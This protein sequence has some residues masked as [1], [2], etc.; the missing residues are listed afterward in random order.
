MQTFVGSFLVVMVMQFCCTAL[1]VPVSKSNAIKPVVSRIGGQKWG[2][3]G[4][5]DCTVLGPVSSF[6]HNADDSEGDYCPEFI[7]DYQ[8]RKKA[9]YN[10]N[11]GRALEV[12]RRELPMVFAMSNFDFSIFA[13]A[14][15][16]GDGNRNKV[17]MQKTLYIT[18]VSSLRLASAFSSIYPSMNVKK[19]Q[20]VEESA[21]IQ[22]LVD[23]LL[24]DSVRIDGQAVWEGMI[25]FGL[26]EAGL[27]NSQVFDRKISNLRPTPAP[28]SIGK[29]L[30]SS[31]QWS[32]DL[33][34]KRVRGSLVAAMEPYDTN[35]SL[36]KLLMDDR[37]SP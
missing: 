32:S 35:D 30:F 27:I 26:D 23:V 9:A 6:A 16:V 18:A 14:I 17:V 20:Y 24:P 29:S 33:I 19:I 25:Y 15:T 31:P 34:S 1:H 2:E 13:P 4:G 12:L 11:V 37:K 28:S 36:L 3:F 7:D 5:F 10:L 21:T 8:K 22:C